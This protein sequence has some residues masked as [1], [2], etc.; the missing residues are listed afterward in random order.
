MHTILD[1]LAAVIIAPILEWVEPTLFLIYYDFQYI[2]PHTLAIIPSIYLLTTQVYQ[3]LLQQYVFIIAVIWFGAQLLVRFTSLLLAY[4]VADWTWY[5]F[6]LFYMCCVHMLAS[7][8]FTIYLIN[9]FNYFF[10]FSPNLTYYYI[11]LYIMSLIMFFIWSIL[12][13]FY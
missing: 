4:L 2:L 6:R 3:S 13:Y 11:M 8:Y 9:W 12:D 7:D 5:N 10:A 1:Y